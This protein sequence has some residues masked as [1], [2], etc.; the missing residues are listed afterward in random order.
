[1]DRIRITSGGADRNATVFKTIGEILNEHPL[2]ESD[3][4]LTH[5]GVRPFVSD[6]IINENIAAMNSF[7]AVTT[8]LPSTDTILCSE[9]GS[10]I[11]SVPERSKM[12]RAQTPQTFRLSKLISAYESLDENQVSMLTDTASVFTTAGLDVGLVSGSETNIKITTPYDMKLAEM[13]IRNG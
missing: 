5:D 13:I 8:A 2:S 9:D 11:D 1:M 3:I 4:V 7:A 10:R 6:E 12:F